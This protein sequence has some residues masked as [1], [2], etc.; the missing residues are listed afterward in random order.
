MTTTSL[1]RPRPP[2]RLFLAAGLGLVGLGVLGYVVQ[3][4]LGYLR[5][6][7][8]LPI[9]GALGVLLIVLSLRQARTVWRVLALGLVGLLTAVG[10]VLLVKARLPD[11]AGPVKVDEPFPAFEVARADGTPFTQRDLVGDKN[12]LMV[13][14]RGRW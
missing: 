1:S 4:W 6:P 2:G 8:Y 7:R 13:F 14:F 10:V 9:T 12:S 5:A 11:Y 3:L